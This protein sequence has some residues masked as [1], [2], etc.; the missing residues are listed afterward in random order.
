[1]NAFESIVG[2]CLEEEGYWV[3][4]SVKVSISKQ[5]KRAI[6]SFSMPTPE[7]DIVALN[8][9]KNELL[10]LEV[11]SL[12]GSYGVHFEAVTGK[13]TEDAKRYKLFTNSRFRQILTRQL[14]K[15]YIDQGLI[16]QNTTIRY[17]LAA[18]HI[19][20]GDEPKIVQ[21][22]S[23]KGWIIFTPAQIKEKVRRLSE[24]GW[25]DDLVTMTAKLTLK[26]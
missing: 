25:E 16:K 17:G 22:F 1:M 18:G 15:E 26:K 3:R 10:L 20:S 23:K 24:K 2:R 11:K 21:H 13:D 19:H 7:I 9:K 12:L 8:V 14:K 5:E 6:G 4:H